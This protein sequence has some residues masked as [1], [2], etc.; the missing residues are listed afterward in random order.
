[1]AAASYENQIETFTKVAVEAPVLRIFQTLMEEDLSIC[2][3][4]NFSDLLFNCNYRELKQE[5][6]VDEA[7]HDSS[8]AIA[9][10]HP[11]QSEPNK[12]AAF[13]PEV[14][15]SE[16]YSDGYGVR[17]YSEGSKY[18]AFVY[19]YKAAHE[20][21]TQDL[22]QALVKEKLFMEVIE[23]ICSSKVTSDKELQKQEAADTQVAKALTQVFH[24]MVTY[25]V[26]YGYITVG[27]YLLFLHIEMGNLRTLYYHLCVPDEQAHNENGP[28]NPF[29]TAVAQLVSFCLLSLGSE[30]FLGFS[31][32]RA[33]GKRKLKKWGNPYE[34]E[35]SLV[36][37]GGLDSSESAPSQATA[38]SNYLPTSKAVPTPQE[39]ALRSRSTCKDITT[40]RKDD[41]DY[42]DE[43]DG[44]PSQGPRAPATSGA[45]KRK[46]GPSSSSPGGNDH[47]SS[48]DS[49][50]LPT[51]QY[52]RVACSVL[53]GDVIWMRTALTYCFIAP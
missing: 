3:E 15:T 29:Y 35:A 2:R 27:K 9:Q 28:F 11:R 32:D 50:S 46:E 45:N 52:C 37:I 16:A 6:K 18:S 34:E 5:S 42:D 51:R 43:Q 31:V 47:E 4:F 49:E 40:I 20:L 13:D 12:R 14:E 53:R 21:T 24:Y 10:E 25:G 1:M 19:D 8:R 30:P 44:G 39:F 38:G 23:R 22:N 33:T 7:V 36:N 17:T 41:E 26:A 48:L